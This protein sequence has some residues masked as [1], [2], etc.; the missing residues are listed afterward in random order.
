MIPA[1]IVLLLFL[2]FPFFV[3]VS[4]MLK[5]GEGRVQLAPLLVAPTQIEW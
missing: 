5:S 4:T 1:V 3:M 2:L